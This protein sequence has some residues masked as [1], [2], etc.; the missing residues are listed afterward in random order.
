MCHGVALK[1]KKKKI[2]RAVVNP[3]PPLCGGSLPAVATMWCDG[4]ESEP[5]ALRAS[6]ESQGLAVSDVPN[7]SL[8]F[9][10]A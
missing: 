2:F 6:Y 9:N 7:I 8:L 1:R 10:Q 4:G 3:F 5:A